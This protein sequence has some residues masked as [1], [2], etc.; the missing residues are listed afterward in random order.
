MEWLTAELFWFLLG[1]VLLVSEFALPGIII[2]FFGI[3]AWVTALTTWLGWTE[4]AASQNIVFAVSSVVFLFVLR[5]RFKKVFV[6][7]STNDTIEDEY[8]G[9]EARTLTDIDT[10]HG[11]IEMKGAEWNARSLEPIAAESWVIIERREGLTLHV[12]PR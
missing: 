12:R 1:F 11:K 8:T 2:M 5:N 6:G 9:K 10:Q 3:G 4:S 7:T